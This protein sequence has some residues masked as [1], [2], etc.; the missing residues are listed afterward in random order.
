[1]LFKKEKKKSKLYYYKKGV[2]SFLILNCHR[3][4]AI[5]SLLFDVV[6]CVYISHMFVSTVCLILVVFVLN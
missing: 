5:D 3:N 1:M 4:H 6:L 2:F